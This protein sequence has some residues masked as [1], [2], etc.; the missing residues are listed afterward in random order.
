MKNENASDDMYGTKW[1]LKALRR[2]FTQTGVDAEAAMEA[3]KDV[4]IKT[5]IAVES[6]ISSLVN[7]YFPERYVV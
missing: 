6:D 4:I 3:I 1:S 7:R 2:Y 5:L